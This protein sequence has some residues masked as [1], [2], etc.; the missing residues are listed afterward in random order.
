M[1]S[2]EF[3]EGEHIDIPNDS[4]I[5]PRIVGGDSYLDGFENYVIVQNKKVLGSYFTD[6]K[7]FFPFPKDYKL[8]SNNEYESVIVK[9]GKKNILMMFLWRTKTTPM[10]DLRLLLGANI[11]KSL[12]LNIHPI[13]LWVFI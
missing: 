11:I 2:A 3:P 10:E 7:V 8:V 9:K 1:F 12:I 6:T 4:K 5:F 13:Q